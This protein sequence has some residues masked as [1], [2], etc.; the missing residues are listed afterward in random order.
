MALPSQ[1]APSVRNSPQVEARWELSFGPYSSSRLEETF[2]LFQAHSELHNIDQECGHVAPDINPISVSAHLREEVGLC[3]QNE[4]GTC[5]PSVGGSRQEGPITSSCQLVPCV[6]SLPWHLQA[7]RGCNGSGLWVST[8]CAWH[9]RD[10]FPSL[11]GRPPLGLIGESSSLPWS[12]QM[13]TQVLQNLSIRVVTYTNA[14]SNDIRP[15]N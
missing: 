12:C 9:H 10:L 1:S 6:L 5:S 2:L 13:L 4:R 3:L 15:S 11:G 7:W 14:A 8:F